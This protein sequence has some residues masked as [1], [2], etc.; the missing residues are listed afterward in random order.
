MYFLHLDESEPCDYIKLEKMLPVI[1]F[2]EIWPTY[3]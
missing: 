3:S 1:D 2:H